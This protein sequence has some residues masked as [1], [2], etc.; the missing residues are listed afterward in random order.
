MTLGFDWFSVPDGDFNVGSKTNGVREFEISFTPVTLGQFELFLNAT[1]YTP[2][3][4]RIRSRPGYLLDY[5]KINSDGDSNGGMYC[6][7]Y[8]DAVAFCDWANVRLPTDAELGLF[9]DYAVRS[10]ATFVYA[11][12][13]WTCNSDGDNHFIAR[14]GPYQPQQL[15]EPDALFRHRLHRHQWEFDP[16]PCVRVIRI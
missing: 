1:D 2:V 5:A 9:F 6:I 8:D 3:P 13:C 16:A 12:E 11:G 14:D 10:G 4:D 7:T 15:S